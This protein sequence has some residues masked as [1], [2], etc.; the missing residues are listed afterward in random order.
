MPPIMHQPVQ[1]EPHSVNPL[2][3]PALVRTRNYRTSS[4]RA[5]LAATAVVA[6]LVAL[7][8]AF[9]PKKYATAFL[10]VNDTGWKMHPPAPLRSDP[11]EV[12]AYRAKQI[13][14][15]HSDLVLSDAL[16]QPGMASLRS[17][18]GKLDPLGWLRDNLQTDYIN[19]SGLLRVRL[20][21]LNS[22]EAVNL[23]NAV[24]DAYFEDCVNE[25]VQKR[26]RHRDSL[27]QL[28]EQRRQD[29]LP[30]L[31]RCQE[32]KS[33]KSKNP[34]GKTANQLAE[35]DAEFARL[36]AIL[37]RAKEQSVADDNQMESA[38]MNAGEPARVR[39]VA[40]AQIIED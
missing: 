15:L 27:R 12:R 40:D 20:T 35:Q 17:V 1:A 23:V 34:D 22:K 24:I 31:L 8:M 19:D 3:T 37:D 38:K 30:I 11:T 9:Q 13:E 18:R 6:V 33:L 4:V 16:K 2:R 29:I 32:L 14:F 10:Q 39:K 28:Q 36:K 25:E 26:I 5:L 7:W 21:N